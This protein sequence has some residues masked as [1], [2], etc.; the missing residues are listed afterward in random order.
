MSNAD[1]KVEFII[2][3]YKNE[4]T[5]LSF[6]DK[7]KL[8]RIWID[9]CIKDEEYEMAAAIR[10]EKTKQVKKHIKDKLSK[11]KFKGY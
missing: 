8:A 6:G 4:C 2:A 10:E 5:K 1:R 3:W 9:I 7:I 11:R